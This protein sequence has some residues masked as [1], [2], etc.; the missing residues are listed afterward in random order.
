MITEKTRGKNARVKN[1]AK[2]DNNERREEGV[3][4]DDAYWVVMAVIATVGH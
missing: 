1:R 4:E 2:A 3:V